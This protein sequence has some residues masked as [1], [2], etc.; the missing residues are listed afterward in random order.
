MNVAPSVTLCLIVR[1][2]ERTLPTLLGS[3]E[4]AFDET[5]M[6][7]D[8]RDYRERPQA[9]IDGVRVEP[10]WWSTAS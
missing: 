2:G 10:S 7:L 6:L 1:D 4:Y 8:P 9:I 5:L 3:I